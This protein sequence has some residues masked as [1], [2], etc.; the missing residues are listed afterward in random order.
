MP[1][2]YSVLYVIT[3]R[4]VHRPPWGVSVALPPAAVDVNQQDL[5]KAV[6]ARLRKEHKLREKQRQ[7]EQEQVSAKK[8]ALQDQM[9]GQQNG[10]T[11]SVSADAVAEESACP[12]ADGGSGAEAPADLQT[13]SPSDAAEP[14]RLDQ[15][16]SCQHL[17]V[18]GKDRLAWTEW[19]G[20]R[21]GMSGWYLHFAVPSKTKRVE[22]GSSFMTVPVDH[23]PP[24]CKSFADVNADD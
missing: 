22:N 9:P 21:I 8:Q 24:E 14:L 5:P 18:P 19:L 17:P 3:V 15:S 16:A 13:V 7:H 2:I 1:F 10:S 12:C 20:K 23:Q 6:Q 4:G 11:E